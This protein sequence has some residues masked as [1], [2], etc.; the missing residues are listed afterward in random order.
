MV[1]KQQLEEIT[2]FTGSSPNKIGEEQHETFAR[3]FEAYIRFNKYNNPGM[4]NVFDYFKGLLENIYTDAKEL[5]IDLNNK[6]MFEFFDK[7]LYNPHNYKNNQFVYGNNDDDEDDEEKKKQREERERIKEE[8]LNNFIPL[9][10]IP[11]NQKTTEQKIIDN[12]IKTRVDEIVKETEKQIEEVIEAEYSQ[13]FYQSEKHQSSQSD[14]T[15]NQKSQEEIDQMIKDIHR[16]EKMKIEQLLESLPEGYKYEV[17]RRYNNAKNAFI[18]NQY[19][20]K[21]INEMEKN[22]NANQELKDLRGRYFSASDENRTIKQELNWLEQRYLFI[23][24][25][26]NATS[27]EIE[28]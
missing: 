27:K 3:G 9:D 11:D 10:D 8:E 25:E 17:L 4:K 12:V 28:N 23:L 26:N 20:K 2:K 19:L 22:Y 13:T 24:N 14:Q 1:A 5:G 21:K 7:Y 15:T 18:Q 6:H 16:I